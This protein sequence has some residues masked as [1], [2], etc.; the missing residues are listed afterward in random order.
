MTALPKPQ[1]IMSRTRTTPAGSGLPGARRI[2]TSRND[3]PYHYMVHSPHFAYEEY[4]IHLGQYDRLSFYGPAGARPVTV[5]L[6]DCR[7]DSPEY[8]RKL[9][10]DVPADGSCVL[11]VPP[12]Y[13]HW[14][15]HLGGVTTRN[16]YSLHAP[17]DPATP[18]N[19]LDDNAT[20]PVEEMRRS[21]PAVTANTT[22]LPSAA[23]FLVAKAVS[24]S[25]RGGATEQGVVAT[26]EIAGERRRYFIDR[27]LTGDRP[28]LPVS[29]L[30][31]VTVE[32]GSYQ[33][34]R[35]DS[36]GIGANVGNGLAD[37]MVCDLSDAW[38]LDFSAHPHLTLKLSPLLYDNPEVE[39]QLVDRR[40]DSP[41]FGAAQVLP[42]PR[43][44]RAVVT[45]EP[46][47]LMRARGAGTLHYRV[48]YE[49]HDARSG[50]PELFVPVPGD[51]LPPTFEAP[52]GTLPENVVREL[53]YQ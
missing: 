4:A 13:A 24:R 14:F 29:E 52:G 10:I 9:E 17:A 49:V 12:G 3:R 30:A 39:L 51:A 27:D 8:D 19:P 6:Y 31:T 21:R 36:Y 20:H 42:F 47:V 35:D 48:E 33:S 15:E 16:D 34:I 40:A 44:P 37:T 46:G 25:W 23:Q 28:E 38:P 22:E 11:A 45:V 5:H 26:A 43:D 50:L 53:A 1:L 32:V 18:W 7:A 2:R 41:T